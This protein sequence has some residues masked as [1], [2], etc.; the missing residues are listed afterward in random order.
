MY[1]QL[2]KFGLLLFAI[3]LTEATKG[4]SFMGME[5]SQYA[6]ISNVTRQPASINGQ[7][8]R[9]DII[10]IGF[11]QSFTNNYVGI[12]RSA[13]FSNRSTAW[14]DPEFKQ[15]YLTTRNNPRNKTAYVGTDI[16]GPGFM[17]QLSPKHA[18]AFGTRARSITL[19]HNFSAEFASLI[20]NEFNAPDLWTRLSNQNADVQ[21]M[22]WIE[23]YV[24]YAREIYSTEQHVLRAGVTAKLL[25]GQLAAYMY[26]EDLDYEFFNAEEFALYNTTIRYGHSDN[27]Q[28]ANQD[29]P[30]DFEFV[31]KPGLGIDLGM[32]YE[33]RSKKTLENDY[34]NAPEC[35]YKQ[36]SYQLKLAFSVTDMG[37]IKFNKGPYGGEFFADRTDLSL[38][39]FEVS[40]V[41]DLDTTLRNLF[42]VLPYS[43][44][45]RMQLPLALNFNADYNLGKGFFAN[46]DVMIAPR[47][48][49]NYNK[50]QH[51]SRFQLTPRWDSKWFGVYVPLSVNTH[52]NV[53]LGMTLRA[54]PLTIG[55]NDLT[56]FMGREYIYA[57]DV[58]MALKIPI[59][60]N[61]CCGKDKS[62]KRKASK[63]GRSRNKGGKGGVLQ[64]PMPR[65]NA[66]T[67][68]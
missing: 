63:P 55:T 9:M 57:Q 25:Q 49:S 44:T 2:S 19:A 36:P 46:L 53:G 52:G 23:Y 10:L 68:F 4:Q 67:K 50:V 22:S 61:N 37:A 43:P 29:A 15:N 30:Y 66:D 20:Y 58:H 31:G 33:Y 64:C 21:H 7:G 34:N 62:S 39:D 24:T 12:H 5:G 51:I 56:A 60:F 6:G 26:L 45:F 35:G 3:F 32:E 59:P 41:A 48:Q 54:G 11:D 27:P 65:S 8:I 47:I 42:E 40:S 14:S 13:L 38:S 28:F 17:M 18:F 1:N 16:M